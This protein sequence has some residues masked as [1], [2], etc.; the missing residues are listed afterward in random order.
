MTVSAFAEK[1]YSDF[2][3]VVEVASGDTMYTI[4]QARG[5][6]YKNVKDAIVIVN[7]LSSESSL[8]AIKP[9]Q[10]ILIPTSEFAAAAIVQKATTVTVAQIPSEYVT[11][12]TVVSGD[13]MGK[14]CTAKGIDYKACS[15]V[16]MKLNGWTNANKLAS[17]Y[18]NQEVIL[19][20]S[21]GA[22]ALIALIISA[23]ESENEGLVSTAAISGDTFRYY[24]VKH[25]MPKGGSLKDV[26]NELGVEYSTAV[27]K[28][29]L[30]LNKLAK[31]N[32]VQAG[33]NYWFLSSGP[34]ST[35]KCYAVYAHK[36]DGGDTT[37]NL[38]SAY[39][40]TFS[41]V[42]SI[43]EGLNPG[44]NFNSIKK[45]STL[46]LVTENSAAVK[47]PVVIA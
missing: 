44:V 6:Q 37:G 20:V 18:P 17:I 35:G 33:E 47:T 28:Q 4:C 39:G 13:T 15:A 2:V 21:D 36:V 26:S 23:A 5:M 25:K 32:S 38:C 11:R 43:L 19:P 14:I 41:K 9:G 29:L 31:P 7:K 16:I 10:L 3:T 1:D 42:S 22:A 30:K 34:D 45:N 24:L 27:E 40:V 12:Y 46:L 8:A